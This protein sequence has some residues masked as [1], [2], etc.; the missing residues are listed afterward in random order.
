MKSARTVV[1]VL[2][3]SIST[4]FGGTSNDPVLEM[5]PVAP[6]SDWE[7]Q[8]TIYGWLPG[9]DGD[10]GVD[11]FVVGVD[12]TFLDLLPDIKMFTMLRFEARKAKWGVIADGF[13]VDLGTSGNPPGNLYNSASLD[14]KQFLGELSIAYRV[15]E[16]PS[17]FVDLYAGARYN[18]FKIDLGGSLNQAGIQTT[19]NSTSM[20][21]V[22]QS[23]ARA[24]AIA[25][26]V[27]ASYQVAAPAER[28]AIEADLAADIQADVDAQVKKDVEQRVDEILRDNGIRER[29]LTGGDFSRSVKIVRDELTA[30]TA[31]LEVA[32]LRATVDAT[33]QADV[34]TAEAKLQK[35]EQDLANAINGKLN[36]LPTK[37]SSDLD[38]VDPIVGFRAQWNI[39]EKWF[40]AGKSDIGGFGVG[41]ELAWTLQATV[42][43]C[44]NPC[45]SVELGY[46]YMHTDYDADSVLY[47][48][49]EAGI[50]MSY[51]YK[52]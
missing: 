1:L 22:D 19:S 46:R 51:H 28:A 44:I 40:L 10:V 16:S 52:F 45:S 11:G 47:D 26:P 5:P 43:Y 36:K 48:V 23:E 9:L 37:K 49:A 8:A 34:A 14:L 15:Y 3:T 7:F 50:Y 20:K 24:K 12:E 31:E 25:E 33:A 2:A 30:A 17:G 13:Y 32:R 41:S 21:I 27:V 39:N 35:S 42:G 6:V 38:W 18:G 29:D 4:I